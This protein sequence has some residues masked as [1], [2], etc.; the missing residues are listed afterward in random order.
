[1]TADSPDSAADLRPVWVMP[2]HTIRPTDEDALWNAVLQ[3]L[4]LHSG[5]C[6]F[7]LAVDGRSG[8]GKSRLAER[9]LQRARKDLGADDVELFHLEDLYPGWEG[10]EEGVEAF[11]GML[12]QLLRNQD[13]SWRPW[14]WTRRQPSDETRLLRANARMII[15]EGVGS[16]VPGHTDVVPHF[17]VWLHLEANI[18]KHRALARDGDLYRPYWDLWAA[19]EDAL[20]AR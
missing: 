9:L 4:A 14:D 15:V 5:P 2:S 17:G 12:E 11:A 18:R 19:Q 6:P 13:A 20:F 1:M 16:T 10:L 8:A 7:L 3:N